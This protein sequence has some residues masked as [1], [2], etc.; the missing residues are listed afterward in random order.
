MPLRSPSSPRRL[1]VEPLEA[2]CLQASTASLLGGV[3]TVTGTPDRDNIHVSLDAASGQLVVRSFADVVGRFDSAAVA[4]IAISTGAGDD[5]VLIDRA[6]TQPANIDGGSGRNI[7]TGGGGLTKLLGGSG[8][9]KLIAG[10]GATT[11]NGNGG[12]NLLFDVKPID[13]PIIGPMDR[14]S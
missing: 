1:S 10:P 11:L 3:L 6:I 12:A 7:L 14:V 13:T 4:S 8:P 5:I 2:R 9:D